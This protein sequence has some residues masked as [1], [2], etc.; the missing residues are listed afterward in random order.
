MGPKLIDSFE[1][2]VVGESHSHCRIGHKSA[3]GATSF[4]QRWQAERSMLESEPCVNIVYADEERSRFRCSEVA[5]MVSED[6][7][8][9]DNS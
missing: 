6:E 2:A 1:S 7:V 4:R 3:A 8:G 9:G 5:T